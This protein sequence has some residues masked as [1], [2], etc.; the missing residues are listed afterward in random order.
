VIRKSANSKRVA[1]QG[2]RI[3]SAF[4]LADGRVVIV[5]GKR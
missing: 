2:E 5:A 1:G 4:R 3:G